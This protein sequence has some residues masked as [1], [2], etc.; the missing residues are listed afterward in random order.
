MLEIVIRLVFSLAVVVGLLLLLATFS[1]K[2]FRGSNGALI[3]VVARQPLTR[4]SAIAVV[5]VADRVLV[6]GT[7]ENEVRLL[8]ELD[9]DSL[10]I[11]DDPPPQRTSTRSEPRAAQTLGSGQGVTHRIDPLAPDLEAGHGRC[12]EQPAVRGEGPG[13][14]MTDALHEV[15]PRRSPSFCLR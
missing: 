15:A 10:E 7:T 4:T 13:A 11:E 14:P 12:D 1:S 8:T 5:T 6:V 2:K 9:P 3:Q